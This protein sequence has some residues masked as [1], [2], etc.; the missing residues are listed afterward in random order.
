MPIRIRQPGE[1]CWINML[2]PDSDAAREFFSQVLGWTYFEMPGV[3]HG[4]KA[5]GHDIGGLFDTAHPMTPPGTQPQIGVMIKVENADLIVSRV[6]SLGGTA[7]PAFDI[8]DQ[9]RMAVC[10]DPAG[11][12]FDVWEP[13]KMLG[14]DV[15]P[16]LHG[17]PSW[18]E[19][20]TT[21]VG[22][23][24]DFYA[25]L[26][27]WT[28]KLTQIQALEYTIFNLRSEQ[29]AGLGERGPEALNLRSHW[30]AHFAVNDIEVA[31]RTATAL[32]ANLNMPVQAIPGIGHF[33]MITSPQGVTFYCIQYVT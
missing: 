10:H 15:D 9:G 7:L 6:A 22:R 27:G 33:C 3:G 32:G 29:V 24:S 8:G 31:A 26:F 1:F 4:I 5:S 2:T 17:A 30:A 23:V 16:H 14:T 25:S 12:N 21:D 20:Q 18:F 13:K 19:N 11:A 28:P